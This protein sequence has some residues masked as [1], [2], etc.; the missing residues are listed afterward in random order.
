[1]ERLERL[2]QLEQ[3]EPQLEQLEQLEPQLEP[4]QALVPGRCARAHQPYMQ[5][6]ASWRLQ[7]WTGG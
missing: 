7:P 2:E 3:L 6:A 4:Q 5:A 1:L